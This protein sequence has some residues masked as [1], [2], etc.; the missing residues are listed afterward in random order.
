MA[1]CQDPN[2]QLFA[3][4]F[5]NTVMYIKLIVSVYINATDYKNNSYFWPT[6]TNELQWRLAFD[7][8]I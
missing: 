6:K 2:I 4:Y 5:K 3:A 8:S 1:E 7:N